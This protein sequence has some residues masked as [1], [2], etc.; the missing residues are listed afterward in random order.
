MWT[1]GTRFGVPAVRQFY[2]PGEILRI[3]SFV[4][5]V[6]KEVSGNTVAASKQN[7]TEV[8]SGSTPLSKL[9]FFLNSLEVLQLLTRNGRQHE[10]VKCVWRRATGYDELRRWESA[11]QSGLR[12]AAQ[13]EPEHLAAAGD[14]G[15]NRDRVWRRAKG[16]EQESN[17]IIIIFLHI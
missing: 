4:H 17:L 6:R 14:R 12:V 16:T 5:P 9:T 10:L 15:E 13:P 1:W 11:W 3:F 7:Q 2:G 8:Y